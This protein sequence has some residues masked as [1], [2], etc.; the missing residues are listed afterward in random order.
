MEMKSFSHI[1]KKF[2]TQTQQSSKCLWQSCTIYATPGK[3][4]DSRSHSNVSCT[5]M[6][7]SNWVSLHIMCVSL[8]WQGSFANQ[9]NFLC[10]FWS[11]LQSICILKNSSL[12]LPHLFFFHPEKVT[13]TH[14]RKYKI[15]RFTQSCMDIPSSPLSHSGPLHSSTNSALYSDKKFLR[16]PMS[17]SQ[18]VPKKTLVS[19]CFTSTVEV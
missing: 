6:Y 9:Q 3:V 19:F 15:E 1:L 4:L 18:G 14:S 17:Q 5:W 11:Q 7:F 16:I 13:C 2:N 12:T 10:K 8:W